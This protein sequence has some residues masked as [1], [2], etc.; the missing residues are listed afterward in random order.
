ML[1]HP[2]NTATRA[3][4]S[5]QNNSSQNAAVSRTGTC[6]K[7]LF[8]NVSFNHSFQLSHFGWIEMK[9]HL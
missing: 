2:A 9:F 6:I 8:L 3:N 7:L 5:P 1:T 4:S